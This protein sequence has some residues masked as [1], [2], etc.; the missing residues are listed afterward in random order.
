MEI[1]KTISVA[2]CDF[3]GD[4]SNVWYKC[5]SCKVDACYDCKK[6]HGTEFNHSVYCSGSGDGWYCTTCMATQKSDD[7][8]PLYMA[9]RDLRNELK[10]FQDEFDRRRADAETRLRDQLDKGSQ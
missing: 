8:L 6:K 5:R 10:R 7:A 1:Q 2:Q 9:I 4:S 3:C